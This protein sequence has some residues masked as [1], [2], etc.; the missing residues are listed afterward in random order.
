MEHIESRQA[1]RERRGVAQRYG[2]KGRGEGV[3]GVLRERKTLPLQF[4]HRL[5]ANIPGTLSGSR[6]VVE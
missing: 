4:N 2:A 3:P 6:G 1:R 5:T